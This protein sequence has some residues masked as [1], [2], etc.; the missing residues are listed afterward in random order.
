MTIGKVGRHRAAGD[1]AEGA[2]VRQGRYEVALRDPAHRA[3]QD[4]DLAAEEVGPALHQP[5][6]PIVAEAALAGVRG[7]AGFLNHFA[8]H[9]ASPVSS[10]P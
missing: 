1:H 9:A 3:A 4:G 10:S 5:P 2:G 7:A 6:E 8:G